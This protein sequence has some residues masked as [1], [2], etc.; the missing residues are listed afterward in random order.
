MPHVDA[1]EEV[2]YPAVARALGSPR[3]TASMSQDRVEIRHLTE[4]L[5]IFRARMFQPDFAMVTANEL[6][7]VLYGLY[8]IVKLHFAKEE[9]VY[10]PILDSRLSEGDAHE[11]FHRIAEFA[12]NEAHQLGH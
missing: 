12:H 6:R 7:R 11:L 9:E 5:R 2:L 8:S 10:L 4:Q 1:E 3:A